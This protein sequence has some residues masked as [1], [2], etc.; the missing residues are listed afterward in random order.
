MKIAQ[1]NTYV[2]FSQVAMTC[3]GLVCSEIENDLIF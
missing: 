2:K 3:G 1:D